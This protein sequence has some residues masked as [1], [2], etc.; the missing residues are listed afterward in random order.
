MAVKKDR[1]EILLR[2]PDTKKKAIQDEVD[3]INAALPGANMSMQ[4]WIEAAIDRHLVW[5]R[6]TK[7][8]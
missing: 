6:E 8:I 1:V 4:S 2:I 3:R 7:S 5:S